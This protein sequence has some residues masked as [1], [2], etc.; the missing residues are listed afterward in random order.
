MRKDLIISGLFTIF[1]YASMTYSVQILSNSGLKTYKYMNDGWE[2]FNR[3]VD[4]RNTEWQT[5]KKL[6][7]ENWQWFVIHMILTE[8]YRTNKL[9]NISLIHFIVGFAACLQMFNI[10]IFILLIFQSLICYMTSILLNKKRYVWLLASIFLLILNMIKSVQ[11][12]KII[13][14]AMNINESKVISFM[15]AY[16]WCILK[17]ISFCLEMIEN[18][19]KNADKFK[20]I[21][22]LGYIFYLPTF[23]CGPFFLYARYMA[24]LD[25]LKWKQFYT[26]GTRI[27]KLLIQFIKYTFLF[28]MIEVGLHFLYIHHILISID[29]KTLSN[30][31]LAGIGF[32]RSMFF[33]IKYMIFYGLSIAIGEFE[34][35]LM[36]NVPKCIFRIYKFSDMWK[37]FDHG[38]YEFLFKYIYIQI[39]TFKSLVIKLFAS[40]IT[41]FFIYIWHGFYKFVFI[42]CVTNFVCIILEKLTYKLIESNKFNSKALALLK[43]NENVQFIKIVIAVNVMIPAFISNAFFFGGYTY[44]IECLERIYAQGFSNYLKILSSFVLLYPLAEVVKMYQQSKTEFSIKNN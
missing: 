41:F 40:I 12:S 35:I 37:M 43:T 39:T 36:P 14:N 31:A 10:R 16:A 6:I 23:I 27:K 21:N 22:C 15:V 33:N 25:Y 20:L 18:N 5:F 1:L 9:Y 44:G 42:W 8:M 28:I 24:M 30:L 32:L 38:L 13:M 26:F 4:N 17:N 3:K 19:E 29:V 2:I 7:E 34:H 11:Y